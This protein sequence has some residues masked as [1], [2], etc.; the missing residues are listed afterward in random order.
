MHADLDSAD[1]NMSELTRRLL[2]KDSLPVFEPVQL[3]YRMLEAQ[4]ERLERE[5]QMV[6]DFKLST[7]YL[8]HLQKEQGGGGLIGL[9][10]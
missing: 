3:T 8:K 7:E 9:K 6:N 4:G 1:A 5:Q 2:R 10:G